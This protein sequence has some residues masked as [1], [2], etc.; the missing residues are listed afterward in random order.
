MQ[1]DTV[2]A[3]IH[4]MSPEQR[5]GF[6]STFL[7]SNNKVLIRLYEVLLEL[8]EPDRMEV[9]TQ[10]DGGIL[11]DFLSTGHQPKRYNVRLKDLRD[12]LVEHVRQENEEHYSQAKLDAMKSC[13]LVY[14]KMRIPEERD[15]TLEEAI[16]YA[17]KYEYY[18]QYIELMRLSIKYEV[19]SK[20][21]NVQEEVTKAYAKI[22]RATQIINQ[23]NE[24]SEWKHQLLL[25]E[26]AGAISADQM[27]MALSQESKS[28]ECFDQQELLSFEAKSQYFQG[29]ACY[30][31]LLGH[32]EEANE[33]FRNA[34]LHWLKHEEIRKDRIFS[35]LAIS[36]NYFFALLNSRDADNLWIGL[37]EYKS[38]Y[39]ENNEAMRGEFFANYSIFLIQ[40]YFMVGDLEAIKAE[41]QPMDEEL[42]KVR[43]GVEIS[44]QV[45][46]PFNLGLA[47]FFDEDFKQA[48]TYFA[49]TDNLVE[50]GGILQHLLASTI[51]LR[52]IMLLDK[53][54]D[55]SIKE[56]MALD[57]DA[58][59]NYRIRQNLTRWGLYSEP[60]K[61]LLKRIKAVYTAKPDQRA[62]RLEKLIELARLQLP[63]KNP[64]CAKEIGVWASAKSKGGSMREEY[65]A[66]MY[67]Y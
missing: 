2:F 1:L 23:E 16:E 64:E 40:Y 22:H 63:M 59:L 7:R 29:K 51:F 37:E 53:Y 45:T 65:Q 12:L 17:E 42:S 4:N 36:A 66:W 34:Y 47:F 50:P 14:H 43:E 44:R 27:E 67:Q 13:V 10:L 11:E 60:I 35:F 52:T 30:H 21:E 48:N 32:R 56:K 28:L 33:A 61:L 49:M 55:G 62:D 20:G 9:M 25:K 38:R 6:E 41:A 58:F 54:L 24:L 46:I 18:T 57:L 5:L 8:E 15:A 31:K 19:F 39:T 26:R 3:L